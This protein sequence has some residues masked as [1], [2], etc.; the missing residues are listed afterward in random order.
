MQIKRKRELVTDN[1][2]AVEYVMNQGRTCENPYDNACRIEKRSGYAS[3][4]IKLEDG[5]YLSDRIGESY[6]N[7]RHGD[8]IM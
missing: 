7:W 3:E 5:E 4:M 6:A 1:N 2:I 8:V